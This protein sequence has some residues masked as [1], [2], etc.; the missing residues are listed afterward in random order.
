[1][2]IVL[3]VLLGIVITGVVLLTLFIL[4]LGYLSSKSVDVFDE[5]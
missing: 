2:I 5:E 3:K 1:M 4:A